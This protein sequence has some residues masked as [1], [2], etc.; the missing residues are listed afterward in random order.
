MRRDVLIL[1]SFVNAM[2]QIV[3]RVASRRD[4][5]S[6]QVSLAS[7]VVSNAYRRISSRI[8]R[9]AALGSSGAADRD[10]SAQFEFD[11]VAASAEMAILC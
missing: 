8:H 2:L 5:L 3:H 1:N 11:H 4:S 10:R 6:G 7:D 9:R